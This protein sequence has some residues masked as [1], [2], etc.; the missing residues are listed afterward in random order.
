MLK[1]WFSKADGS[2]SNY[3]ASKI[4]NMIHLL[5]SSKVICRFFSLFVD[6]FLQKKKQQ[7]NPLFGLTTSNWF[8][9]INYCVKYMRYIIWKLGLYFRGKGKADAPWFWLKA[10]AD[11]FFRRG[12]QARQ[13]MG[14]G[15]KHRWGRS[16]GRI[17][18]N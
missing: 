8:Q 15:A 10:H 1:L 2:T 18:T 7:R 6:F 12:A 14:E 13:L 9:T 5:Y 16:L 3:L 17:V 4:L 11:N